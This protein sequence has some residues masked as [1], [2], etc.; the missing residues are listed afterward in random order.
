M[1]VGAAAAA[2]AAAAT[3]AAVAEVVV[4]EQEAMVEVVEVVAKV[5]A[6]AEAAAVASLAV[7]GSKLEQ[8]TGGTTTSRSLPRN[9]LSEAVVEAV[10]GDG[11]EGEGGRVGRTAPAAVVV[12]I[13]APGCHNSPSAARRREEVKQQP[14]ES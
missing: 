6:E 12:P 11:V 2:V 8:A 4:A 1:A 14:S 7:A 9:E 3:E 13:I 10:G 5:V